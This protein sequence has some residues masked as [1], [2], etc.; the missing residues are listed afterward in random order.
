VGRYHAGV[1]SNCEDCQKAVFDAGR[2]CGDLNFPLP[3][4]PELHFSEFNSSVADMKNSV[5]VSACHQTVVLET[6]PGYSNSCSG[7]RH[8]L[9]KASC[10]HRI[11]VMHR[12]R[13][14]VSS[15]VPT[16][17]LTSLECGSTLTWLT[18][19]LR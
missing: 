12:A 13:V 8:G 18:Q 10:S 15:L 16:W 11:V 5:A 7:T 14:P 9:R 19:S 3:Y 6:L 2:T 1:L 4:C 17:G